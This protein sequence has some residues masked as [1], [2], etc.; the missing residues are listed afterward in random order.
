MRETN[1]PVNPEL[2]SALAEDFTT[3]GYDLKRL[4]RT[5]T[6]STTYQLSAVPNEHN[7]KDRQ[8]FSRYY[9]K[10]LTAEVLY[11]AVNTLLAAESQFAGQAPGTRAVALP[12]NS[13]NQTTYFLTVFGRPDSASA[14]ECERTQEASLAQSLHLL[15]ASEIQ[16]QLARADGRAERLAKDPRPDDDKVGDLYHIALSRD[17]NPQELQLA[18]SHLGRK[19]EGK[20]GDGRLAARREAFEDILW[21]LLNTKEFL[22]NH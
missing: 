3:H 5:I 14:C 13:Y 2:L 17:P 16:T 12:D 8:N 6:T 11:D 22:F 21:A 20:D 9:P 7:A 1:P 10:R 4:I 19:T 18:L 15:N